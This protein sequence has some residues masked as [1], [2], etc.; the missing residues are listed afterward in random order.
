MGRTT[1]KA[2]TMDVALKDIRI[3]D[4]I[5]ADL[6]DL[7]ALVDSLRTCGQLNPVTLTRDLE[8]IAGRRRLEAARQLGW[9]SLEARIVD[10]LDAVQRVQMEI[11]ENLCRKDFTSEELIRGIKRLERLQRPSLARRLARRIRGLCRRLCF[12]RKPSV[13]RSPAVPAAHA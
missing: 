1:A 11:Q 5:R 3:P 7:S 8:L 6:G 9:Q 4:R 10:G 13:S 12:W 2:G